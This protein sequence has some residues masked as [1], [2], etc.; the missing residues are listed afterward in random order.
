MITEELASPSFVVYFYI[1]T[2]N[3]MIFS[4]ANDIDAH[5]ECHYETR[6]TSNFQGTVQIF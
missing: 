6:N 4:D 5:D 3:E 1:C 2:N